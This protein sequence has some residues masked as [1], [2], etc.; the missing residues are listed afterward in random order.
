MAWSRTQ[1]QL[2]NAKRS[3]SALRHWI[4]FHFPIREESEPYCTYDCHVLQCSHIKSLCSISLVTMLLVFT[5]IVVNPDPS[6][7]QVCF[8]AAEIDVFS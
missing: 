7:H 2:T 3:I 4:C 5:G 8:P 1:W 6:L